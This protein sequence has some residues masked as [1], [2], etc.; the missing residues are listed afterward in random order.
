VYAIVAVIAAAEIFLYLGIYSPAYSEA[1]L[2]TIIAW[3]IVW[4]ILGIAGILYPY[5]RKELFEA[6]P[7]ATQRRIAGIPVISIPGFLT[8]AV[9]LGTEWAVGQ[10]FV[11][12]DASTLQ[13]V[14]V[15][16][17]MAAPIVIYVIPHFY[18]Q[19]KG[20]PIKTQFSQV[21]PE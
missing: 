10:P 11:K 13:Y 18:H 8:L 16:G 2:Y 14:T 15:L 17:M 9:S 7:P 5:R 21:P 4:I 3:F 19:S 1:I 20:I 12:G 6:G